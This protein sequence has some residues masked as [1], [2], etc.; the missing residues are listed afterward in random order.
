MLIQLSI[1]TEYEGEDSAGEDEEGGED[2][3]SDEEVDDQTEE[4]RTAA[5][6][7]G[8]DKVAVPLESLHIQEPSQNTNLGEDK[9]KQL[10]QNICTSVWN[11][12]ICMWML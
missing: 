6:S 10:E 4:S 8:G 7:D 12:F 11:E 1:Q 5:T 9:G 2:A 3:A